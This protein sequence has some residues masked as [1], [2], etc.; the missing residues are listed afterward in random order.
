MMNVVDIK[1]IAQIGKAHNI[2]VAVDN[3]FASPYLQ[4]PL[5]LGASIVLH[6]ATKYLAGHSDTVLGLLALNDTDIYEKLAFIQN[7]SGAVPGPMDS[8]LTL[9]G[10]KPYILECK[11]TLKTVY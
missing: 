9:R 8:F 6:S 4:Q 3:T 7:A 11:D 2:I 10:L 1:A 5:Q